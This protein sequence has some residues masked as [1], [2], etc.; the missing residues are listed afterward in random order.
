MTNP[1]I[2]RDAADLAAHGQP[3]PGPFTWALLAVLA[4]MAVYTGVALLADSRRTA[5]AV[6]VIVSAVP[7]TIEGRAPR[8]GLL[9]D[10]RFE[11]A[12]G[13]THSGELLVPWTLAQVEAAK[14]CYEPSD[15]GNQS[16]VEGGAT[17]PG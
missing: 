16:L 2:G 6:P 11:S 9:V 10:Y 7:Q 17:C 4:V 3:R 1:P 13:A 15:P 8:P 14:V 12:D 5:E